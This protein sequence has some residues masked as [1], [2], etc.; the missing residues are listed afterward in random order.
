M[1]LPNLK[2][3]YS[4]SVGLYLSRCGYMLNTEYLGSFFKGW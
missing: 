3:E 4:Y 1:E 2:R